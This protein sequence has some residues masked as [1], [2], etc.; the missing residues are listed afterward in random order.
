[1]PERRVVNASPLIVL[2]RAGHL[3]LLTDQDVELIIPEP[4]ASEVV[5]GPEGDARH[6]L[7][8]GWGVRQSIEAVPADILEWGLGS[9]ESAVIALARV[10]GDAVAVLD[11]AQARMCARALG[12]PVIGSL[13]VVIRAAASRRIPAAAPVVRSLRA[14]GL[15]VDDS[16]VRAA[17]SRVLGESWP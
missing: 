15:Y 4:V 8:D 11:D 14:A 9:G 13:G 10:L 17:L 1:V 7:L 2:A 12:V 3:D 6:A 16:V 5:A